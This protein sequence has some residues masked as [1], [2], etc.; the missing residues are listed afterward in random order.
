MIRDDICLMTV[1]LV[2]IVLAGCAGRQQQVPV[3]SDTA[4]SGA[5]G[6]NNVALSGAAETREPSSAESQATVAPPSEPI[7]LLRGVRTAIA[8][9][10]AF[11]S[12]VAQAER[13]ADGDLETAWN[14]KSGDLAG[15]WIDI[16][17]PEAAKVS[18]IELTVG[19]TKAS[20]Q[21]DLF[22]GNHR[23]A[24]VRVS[25]AGEE[26]G[27]FELD[28]ESRELQSMPVEGPGGVYRLEVLKTVP[29][30]KTRWRESCVSELRVMGSAPDVHVGDRLPRFA[31]G[32]LPEPRPE[33]GTTDRVEVGKRLREMTFW[34]AKTW[35]GLIDE[36]G[37]NRTACGLDEAD[38]MALPESHLERALVLRR[39]A[40][41]VELVDEVRADRIR[42]AAIK[43]YRG[44][45]HSWS[46]IQ[47]GDHDL[48]SAGFDAV[49]DWLDDEEARCR[50]A[51]ANSKMRFDLF[52]IEVAAKIHECEHIPMDHDEEHPPEPELE[53]ECAVVY[54]VK[55]MI[56]ADLRPLWEDNPR[57][58]VLRSTRTKIPEALSQPIQDALSA[59]QAQAAVARQSCGW[60]KRSE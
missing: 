15:A 24:R 6:T 13:L 12:K 49:V 40:E 47:G 18:S 59:L 7:D 43:R 36:D 16:R 5:A 19:F 2:F 44:G 57:Q 39:V 54:R 8:T 48:L 37:G 22:T 56:M 60:A 9:S 4:L 50:W 35:G 31:V 14:S 53:R 25:R 32:K 41:L 58:A 34:F 17:L 20:R 1:A 30:T 23:I 45:V 29:G 3:E 51:R 26:V 33:P 27:V 42:L 52:D 46:F 21:R 28:T 38:E 55:G 11:R 10:S